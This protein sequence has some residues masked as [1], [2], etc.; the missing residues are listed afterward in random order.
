MTLYSVKNDSI[1]TWG[2]DSSVGLRAERSVNR[3]PTTTKD[4]F[5]S[6]PKRP[7]AQSPISLVFNGRW[8]LFFAGKEVGA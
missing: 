8:E 2:F 7:V 4:L 6:S 1:V 5:L 3:F